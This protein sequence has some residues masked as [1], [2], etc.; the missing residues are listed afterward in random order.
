LLAYIDSYGW[1]TIGYMRGTAI[2][3]KTLYLPEFSGKTIRAAIAKVSIAKRKPVALNHVRIENWKI[4]DDGNANQ[5]D[6]LHHV[7][8]RMIASGQDADSDPTAAAED[9]EAIKRCLGIN[10]G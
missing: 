1:K 10:G 2:P 3:R 4:D 9:I 6:Q 7:Y 8:S 5:T